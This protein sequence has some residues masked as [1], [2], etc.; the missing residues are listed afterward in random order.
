MTSSLTRTQAVVLGVV[1]MLGLGLAALGLF[2]IGD[3]Q[4]LWK[5]S[6]SLTAEFPQISG[7]EVGT[8]VRVQGINAGQVAAIEM[9]ERRGDKVLVRLKLDT[10]FRHLIGRDA[11]AEIQSEGLIGSKVI[12]IHPGSPDVAAVAPGQVIPGKAD[13]LMD[14]LRRLARDGQ[15]VLQDA[16]VLVQRTTRVMEE[17]ERL[18]SDV[19][20]GQGALGLELI[21]TMRHLQQN[22]DSIGQSFEAMRHLPFVGGYVDIPT[23]TLVRPG[24]VRHVFTFKES[25]LFEPGTAILRP[26]GRTILDNLAATELPRLQVSGSEVVVASYTDLGYDRRAAEILT[27]QQ[28]EAVRTYLVDRHRVHK[29]G[30]WS[31]REVIALG[32]GTRSPPGAPPSASLPP[33]RIEVIVFVPPE[34]GK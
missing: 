4:G 6:F 5:G 12:A 27:Q 23:T 24:A 25:D 15:D 10:R 28:S 8:R 32:M 7:I 26:E 1:V 17:T 22:T 18:V 33:R 19:R 3:R 2:A 30:W 9:P 14:D 20:T 34:S 11:W 21:A 13:L 31:R 29:L 16:R